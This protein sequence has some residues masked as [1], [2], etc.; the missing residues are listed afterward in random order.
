[1]LA[2]KRNI[3]RAAAL[4]AAALI[5]IPTAEAA[6]LRMTA[7]EESFFRALNATR[8]R[9]SLPDVRP[10]ARLQRAARSHSAE[11]VTRGYFAHRDFARRIRRSGTGWPTVGEVLGWSV[12]DGV[13]TRRIVGLWL[14]SPTHR[15]VLL[16]RGFRLVGVGVMRG[17]FKGRSSCV[18]VTADFAGT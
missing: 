5:P 18:V 13:S 4:V 7:S 14:A 9:H 17:P 6:S 11:M 15:A 12:A 10:D 1:M 16:R 2:H 3:R 8:A